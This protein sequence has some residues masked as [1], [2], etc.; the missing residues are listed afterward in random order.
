MRNTL[1]RHPRRI[2]RHVPDRNIQQLDPPIHRSEIN[3]LCIHGVLC[4][5]RPDNLELP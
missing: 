3:V 2:A 1:P 5:L 4:P